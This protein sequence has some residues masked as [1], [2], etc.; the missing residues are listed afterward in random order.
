[1][2][3]NLP[4]PKRELKIGDV[5]KLACLPV[6]TI[7]FYCDQKLIHPVGRSES[8]YRIFD[9][10]VVA[11]LALIK[12]LKLMEFSLVDIKLILEARRSGFCTCTYLKGTIKSK[13]N[14]VD[15]K[16]K[17][18]Q[19]VQGQLLSLIGNWRDC[20]GIKANP[21]ASSV[22]VEPYT[23]ASPEELLV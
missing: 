22:F 15:E 12:T 14:S 3:G 1:M 9:E 2:S 16:I 11:E 4:W 19:Q 21:E 20:G 10:C 7:R 17:E 8:K 18:L 23:K 13:I 5:S 6:K